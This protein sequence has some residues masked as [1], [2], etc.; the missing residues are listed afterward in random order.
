VCVCV[1]ICSL[2]CSL[3]ST[4]VLHGNNLHLHTCVCVLM[5]FTAALSARRC[6]TATICMYVCVCACICSL[7]C[8]L[9]SAPLLHSNDLHVR[10]CVSMHVLLQCTAASSARRCS[11]A[12]IC[13]YVYVCVC[14]CSLACSLV[15]TSLLQGNDQ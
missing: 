3:V 8:S 13:M 15:S 14:F 6:S 10:A 2:A 4:L 11:I 9:V 12:T 5:Q 7:T 1:C